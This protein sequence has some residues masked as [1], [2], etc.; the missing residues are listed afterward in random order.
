[1]PLDPN[2]LVRSGIHTFVVSVSDTAWHSEAPKN[3]SGVQSAA[4]AQMEPTEPGTRH[5][6]MVEIDGK[7]MHRVAVPS[8]VGL[9]GGKL[10]SVLHCC[11]SG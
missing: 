7:T 8:G 11:A 10:P 9:Q 4:V 6:P 3:R 2:R 5:D 1:M